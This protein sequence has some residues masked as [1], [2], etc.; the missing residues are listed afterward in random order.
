M[1]APS[2]PRSPSVRTTFGLGPGVSLIPVPALA[3]IVQS[4]VSRS[5]IP[6]EL[7]DTPWDD[8]QDA[9]RI[10]A[11][12][13]VGRLHRSRLAAGAWNRKGHGAMAGAREEPWDGS[14]IDKPYRKSGPVS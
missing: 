13:S 2:T 12:L 4:A 8:G 6:R 14:W 3:A 1:F 7:R 11:R 5:S 9:S 10:D